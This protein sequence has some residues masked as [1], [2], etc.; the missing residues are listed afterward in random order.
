MCVNTINNDYQM[1]LIPCHAV[2][3]NRS[4]LL[5]KFF[6]PAWQVCYCELIYVNVQGTEMNF[7][8]FVFIKI[9]K[10]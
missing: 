5:L 2:R 7:L 9:K 10:K 1:F 6:Y 4:N 8:L 3:R